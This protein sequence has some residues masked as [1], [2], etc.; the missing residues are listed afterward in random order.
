MAIGSVRMTI[1]NGLMLITMTPQRHFQYSMTT[2]PVAGYHQPTPSDESWTE[3]RPKS[4]SKSNR[5]FQPQSSTNQLSKNQH[6]P[7]VGIE[8]RPKLKIRLS[9]VP[10]GDW[11]PQVKS[12]GPK[13]TD[14]DCSSNVRRAEELNPS[15]Q[16]S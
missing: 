4:N 5:R 15:N 1:A 16:P 6:A 11:S 13:S 9:K 8:V 14:V 2:M 12:S 10:D 3:V 7:K